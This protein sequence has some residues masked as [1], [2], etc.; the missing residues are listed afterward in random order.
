MSR[1]NGALTPDE[2]L[3][4][5]YAHF[6]LG[7]G[8]Q[9]IAAIFGVSSGRITEACVAIEMAMND[10]LPMYRSTLKEEPDGKA[11]HIHGGAGLGSERGD[12]GRP[13]AAGDGL[14]GAAH[15]A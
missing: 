13:P 12:E 2:R 5:A 9:D 8:K 1:N 10:P 6:V 4:A 11:N 7:L 3:R 14:N 15:E